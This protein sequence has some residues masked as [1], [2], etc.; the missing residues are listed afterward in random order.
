M[1]EKQS[2]ALTAC[3]KH[4]PV[5][6][7][8]ISWYL[9]CAYAYYVQDEPM[10]DDHSFDYLCRTL[11]E[12]F[13]DLPDHPHKHLITKDNL[14]AGTYLG[15]YPNM[16]KDSVSHYKWFVLE[17]RHAPSKKKVKKKAKKSEKNDVSIMEK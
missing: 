5:N 6:V 12:N 13:D 16:L 17:W 7:N 1:E 10:T 4:V 8:P 15:E 3:K 2:K 14:K 9:M 11:L